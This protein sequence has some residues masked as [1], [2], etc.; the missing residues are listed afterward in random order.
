MLCAVFVEF[1]TVKMSCSCGRAVRLLGF[2]P[3]AGDKALEKHQV[4]SFVPFRVLSFPLLPFKLPTGQY[5]K[6]TAFPPDKW[7]P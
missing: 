3:D 2:V 4:S 6:N 5:S 7:L 1:F